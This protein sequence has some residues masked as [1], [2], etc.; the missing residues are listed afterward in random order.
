VLSFIGWGKPWSRPRGAD[1]TQRS[2]SGRGD[3]LPLRSSSVRPP[4]I[5]QP[6]GPVSSCAHGTTRRMFTAPGRRTSTLLLSSFSSA[7]SA[8]AKEVHD[9]QQD[10]RTE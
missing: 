5:I 8:P 2:S 4:G 3:R 9:G 6:Q 10:N 1:R 7:H